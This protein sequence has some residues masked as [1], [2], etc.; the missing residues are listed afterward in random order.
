MVI[1]PPR[2]RNVVAIEP[3]PN[4]SSLRISTPGRAAHASSNAPC[5]AI[6]ASCSS[7][8]SSSHAGSSPKPASRTKYFMATPPRSPPATTAGTTMT[9]HAPRIDNTDEKSPLTAVG[10]HVLGQTQVLE[11]APGIE[12]GYGALQAPA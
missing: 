3:S 11:A 6:S 4:A 1:S 9:Q 10:G 12:P 8:V 7:A 2:V 5:L